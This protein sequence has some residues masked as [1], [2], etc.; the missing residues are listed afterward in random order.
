MLPSRSSLKASA[1]CT[2]SDIESDPKSDPIVCT[3]KC[4]NF[5]NKAPVIIATRLAGTYLA[6]RQA[7]I[8]IRVEKT[9]MIACGSI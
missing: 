9:K 1:R 8:R 7:V 3:G 2:G 6:L 5:T 4:P